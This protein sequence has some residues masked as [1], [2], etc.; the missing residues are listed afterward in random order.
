MHADFTEEVSDK[1]HLPGERER[2]KERGRYVREV[3]RKTL[4]KKK[5]QPVSHANIAR[6]NISLNVWRLLQEGTNL[7]FTV[8]KIHR[9]RAEVIFTLQKTLC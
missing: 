6:R 4:K 7:D 2:E 5:H 1:Q 8:C 3:Q 9:L